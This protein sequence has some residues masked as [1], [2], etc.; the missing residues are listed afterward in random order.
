VR[1][2]ILHPYKTTGK[3]TVL[4]IVIFMFFFL[5][6][7]MKVKDSEL[8]GS[9]HSPNLICSYFLS[10]CNFD[11]L[12]SFPNIKEI[13]MKRKYPAQDI[14][15][16]NQQTL[17]QSNQMQPKLLKNESTVFFFFSKDMQWVILVLLPPKTPYDCHD[18]TAKV[19]IYRMWHL[20]KHKGMNIM[21]NF[22]KLIKKIVII[23]IHN[24]E[25]RPETDTTEILH[26]N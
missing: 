8:N 10:E 25:S 24:N 20:I 12:L 18:D 16:M 23:S 22:N 4:Y 15:A 21:L 1:D 19:R 14:T 11:L 5:R 26:R 2:Q 17:L 3:I 9:K 13:L 7:D 6:G